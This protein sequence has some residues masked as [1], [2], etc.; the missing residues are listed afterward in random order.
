MS[1]YSAMFTR[2]STRKFLPEPLSDAELQRLEE[3]L[4]GVRPLLPTSNFT[5][6]VVGPDAVRGLA[7]PDA[8]HFL[9]ISGPK[10]PLRN[11][12]AG[13]LFQHADLYLFA[14]GF[15]ARWLGMVKP[16]VKSPDFIIGIAFGKPAEPAMRTEA[17]FD[18]KPLSEISTGY[19]PRLNAARLAPSGVN[20]QPWFFIVDDDGAI[21]VYYRKQ[22]GGVMG[23]AYHLTDLDVGIALC[24]LA[25]A[26][27]HEG[28]PFH[29]R[30]DGVGAPPAPKGFAYVGTVG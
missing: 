14:H 2:K 18:R 16:K 28:K 7:I 4:A 5:H 11:T 8:P 30:T 12:C 26:S 25:V 10:Q 21:H 9:M 23:L 29:F 1:L 19:D 15:A 27:D 6:Q 20:G 13:F 3:Y 17:E 22:L 24:H